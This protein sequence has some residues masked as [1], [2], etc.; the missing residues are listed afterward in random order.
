MSKFKIAL[1][2]LEQPHADFWQVAFRNSPHCEFAG[3]WSQTPGLAKAKAEQFGYDAWEDRDALVN[4]VDAVAICSVTS[5]HLELI[6]QAA[7]LGKKILCEKPIATSIEHCDAIQQV[8]ERT[9]AYYMQGFPKR[10][11]PL[12]H[13]VRRIIDEG[14]LGHITMVRVRHGHPVG[15]LNPEFDKTWFADPAQGGGGC[16][17]DEG[18]HGA[19]FVRWLFG[20]PEEV[21]CFVADKAQ[22][23]RVEDTAIAIYRY[24]NGMLAEV[25]S[26]WHFMA[27]QNSIEIF[28]TGGSIVVSG[29]D[30]GSRDLTEGEYLK[31]YIHPQHRKEGGDPLGPKDREW[32]VS[33]I[34]PQFKIDTEVFHQNVAR[35]FIDA[36]AEG[37]EPPVT[38]K[39]GRRAVEMILAAYRSAE[40]GRVEKIHYG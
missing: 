20:E 39:D 3:A 37:R 12:N 31:Y 22:K 25:S 38:V 14:G 15:M 10:F 4:A 11:D 1:L 8:I 23:L 26:C 24:S 29:V 2:G 18:V 19:D 9:G 13:E 6:E 35:A 27:A 36:I 30:L 32:T 5:Q 33:D 40:S 21:T 28:G 16:L 17:I 34:I 7:T